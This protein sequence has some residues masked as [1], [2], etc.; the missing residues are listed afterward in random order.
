MSIQEFSRRAF[1]VSGL[2]A[3]GAAMLASQQ[4]SA[5]AATMAA[6]KG[7]RERWLNWLEKLAEPLLA[8]LHSKTLRKTMP[9]EAAPGL[10]ADRAACTHLEALGRLLTGLAPW[11]ELDPSPTES[12]RET[13]LRKKYRTW[14][15]E[16]LASAVDPSSPDYMR[17]GEAG[18]T[19]VDSAFLSLGLLRAPKQLLGAMDASTKKRLI[20]ALESERKIQS[21]FSNWLLFAALNEVLLRKL[22]V[23]WD[24]LRIDYALREHMSWY[25]GD[26][27]YGDG[28]RYHA[29][30]YNSYVIQPF[31]LAVM[32]GL[33]EERHWQ[34]MA[35]PIT[36][37]AHRYAALQERSISPNGEFPVVGRSITYRAGAFHLLA[38]IALRKLLPEELSPAGV[39]S[40]LTAVQQRTLEP[41]GTF[42][43]DGWLQIGL[44]GHQPALGEGYISTGSLYLCSA[45][46]LPLG[47]APEEPFWAGAATDWTQKAIWSGVNRK[48]DH[49]LGDR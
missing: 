41:S 2:Q 10:Q 43:S 12:P 16:A 21:P 15:Q 47:L 38:D 1:L 44:A 3:G 40:A 11:L 37:R 34:E 32:E 25:V 20:A 36:E 42:D 45:A 31:L 19:L 17:F 6:A 27:T 8:A 28:P 23:F 14:A 39:R 48:A 18:Q 29:D 24:R 35:N 30:Y 33:Q 26:G 13:A 9:I 46:L 4:T 5:T 22:N 49:A 7:D